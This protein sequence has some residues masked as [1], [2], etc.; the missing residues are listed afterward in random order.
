L[1]LPRG[2]KK[3][4][5]GCGAGHVLKKASLT[6]IRGRQMMDEHLVQLLLGATL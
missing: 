2:K 3:T 4:D 1:V 5:L 6:K